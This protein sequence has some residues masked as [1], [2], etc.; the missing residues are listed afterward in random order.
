MTVTLYQ[1]AQYLLAAAVIF[2]VA[3]RVRVLWFDAALEAKPI[4]KAVDAM[5]RAGDFDGL[6]A[7]AAR[8]PQRSWIARVL[9]P[10]TQAAPALEA[11]EVA[12]DEALVELKEAAT[13]GLAALRVLTSLATTGG[14]LGAVLELSKGATPDHSLAALEAGLPQRI[15]FANAM[16]SMALGIATAIVCGVCLRALRRDAARIFNDARVAGNSVCAALEKSEQA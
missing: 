4:Q 13:D 9:T 14:L 3:K 8:L 5:A 11:V 6:K 12:V 7:L 2:V 1:V 15:A 10:A 16:N